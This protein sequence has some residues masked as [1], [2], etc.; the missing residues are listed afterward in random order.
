MAELDRRTFIV[1]AAGFA[2]AG[3]LL[4]ACGDDGDASPTSTT[5]TTLL[6]Q[7]GDEPGALDIPQMLPAF[8]EFAMVH[9]VPQRVAYALHDGIDIM[10]ANAPDS[11][12]LVLRFG[13]EV[14]AAEE[15]ARRDVGT[16]TPYYSLHFTPPGAG[17][18]TSVMT[19]GDLTTEHMF[20]VGEP[21]STDVP[22]PGDIL[23][24]I[25]TATFDDA[26]GVDP[27][28]TRSKPCPFHTTDLVDALDAGD[29]PIVLS[30]A[31]PGFC[32]TAIC[33]PVIN[34]LIDAAAERDDLHIVHAEVYVDPHNDPGVATGTGEF[35]PVVAAYALP[36]EPV[37]FVAQADG[38]ILR[39]LDAVYDGSEIAEALALV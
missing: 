2:G 22:Q 10:R 36:Y 23:P 30:I 20:R 39:R 35:T 29:K 33:G 19:Q 26:M 3:A 6:A 11:I 27:L 8:P 18:Y 16:P 15:L 7:N 12:N 38:T 9:S 4:A 31:T 13:D 28:C 32:Q 5:T 34:L 17:V 14:I 25:A 1:S 21:G 24:A 37:L